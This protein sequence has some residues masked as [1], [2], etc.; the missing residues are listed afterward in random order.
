MDSTLS[1]NSE[2]LFGLSQP[3]TPSLTEFFG[4]DCWMLLLWNKCLE[5][6]NS[7]LCHANRPF[8]FGI[9]KLMF[10]P[11]LGS[12]IL[13]KFEI[14]LAQHQS[15]S[16]ALLPPQTGLMQDIQSGDSILPPMWDEC[17]GKVS[18]SCW[19]GVQESKT[20]LEPDIESGML[21]SGWSM[22]NGKSGSNGLSCTKTPL[23]WI[24]FW[25]K[26]VCDYLGPNCSPSLI[27]R[28]YVWPVDWQV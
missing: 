28:M 26:K 14:G 3:N 11:S 9:I 10:P 22:H 17:V 5:T 4:S 15:Q 20:R 12:Y 24:W 25:F 18:N 19:V 13:M 8:T 7:G 21:T 23:K 6:R 2:C 16:Q 1:G 27:I